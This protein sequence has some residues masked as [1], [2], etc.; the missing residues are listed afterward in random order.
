[1]LL[2]ALA[3]RIQ[4]TMSLREYLY[5]DEKRLNSYVEQ[6][7]GPVT[8]DKVPTYVVG[9][10]LAG[11]KAEATQSRLGRPFTSHEKVLRVEEYLREQRLLHDGRPRESGVNWRP[12]G[13]FFVEETRATKAFIPPAKSFPGLA[14]WF[15]PEIKREKDDYFESR[16]LYLFEDY[17]RDDS[18]PRIPPASGYTYL[19]FLLDDNPDFNR[20]L[21]EMGRPR[22]ALALLTQPAE[23]LDAV[24]AKFSDERYVRTLYRV[25]V[26]A[27]EVVHRHD[28]EGNDQG[29]VEKLVVVAYPIY[30]ALA[31]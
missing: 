8:Y 9:V 7:S 15:T 25:R 19:M 5:V 1:V 26:A 22:S 13:E 14:V 6:I 31:G 2:P 23:F 16:H 17:P 3:L 10:S 30:I 11:P 12:E 29:D 18:E 20:V 21:Q 4:A 27:R 24:G 28:D